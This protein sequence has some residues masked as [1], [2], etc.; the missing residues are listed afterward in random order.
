MIYTK[1]W[2]EVKKLINEV[3]DNE[4]SDYDKDYGVISFDIDDVLPLNSIINIYSMT[5]VIRSVFK[6]NN[7]FYPQIHLSN[8]FYSPKNV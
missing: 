7:K 4:F 3:D 5:L 8:C 6:E 1:I 2:E